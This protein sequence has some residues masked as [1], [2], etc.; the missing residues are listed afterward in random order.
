MAHVVARHHEFTVQ[1]RH[2]GAGS[3]NTGAHR[4]AHSAATGFQITLGPVVHGQIDLKPDCG[5]NR[6]RYFAVLPLLRVEL[7]GRFD[8]DR[9]AHRLLQFGYGEVVARD[10][11]FDHGQVLVIGRAGTARQ[12]GQQEQAGS[13]PRI[14]QT[15]ISRMIFSLVSNFL[16]PFHQSVCLRKPKSGLAEAPDE[17]LCTA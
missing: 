14:Q 2:A 10:D 17:Q 13:Q 3:F 12:T 5:R 6:A 9:G 8:R 11:G 16:A 7:R 4:A 1:R 15:L